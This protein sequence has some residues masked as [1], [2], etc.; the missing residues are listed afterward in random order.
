MTD[1]EME[2]PATSHTP[3]PIDELVGESDEDQDEEVQELTAAEIVSSEFP[4]EVIGSSG[5]FDQRELDVTEEAMIQQYSKDGCDCNLG[6]RKMPCCGSITVEHFRSLCS[7]MSELT[8]DELDLVV[9][10]QVMA[11]S[12]QASTFRDIERSR[13]Y[14]AFFHCG[15]RVC[16]KTF[17][18]LHTIG[19]GRF[20]AIKASFTARGVEPRVHGNKGKHRLTGLSLEEVKGVIQFIMNYAGKLVLL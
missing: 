8:H 4:E 5:V 15:G 11:A 13:S 17:L 19:Y 18:F 6:P 10:G 16:Q 2:Q 9:M 20:K 12:F 3:E 1:E 14:T 7:Q